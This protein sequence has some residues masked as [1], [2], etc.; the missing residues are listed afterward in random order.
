MQGE[1]NDDFQGPR[2][3]WLTREARSVHVHLA[4]FSVDTTPGGTVTLILGDAQI[5]DPNALRQALADAGVPAK[6]TPDS[7]CYNPVP[8][9]AALLQ[10]VA[11]H[12][13]GPGAE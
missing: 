4:D 8:D 5:R 2:L 9:R 1:G 12:Q 11:F 3:R 7:V 6:V 13:P 10:A